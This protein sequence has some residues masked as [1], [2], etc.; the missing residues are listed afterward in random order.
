MVCKSGK[1]F[2]FQPNSSLPRLVL[3]KFYCNNSNVAFPESNFYVTDLYILYALFSDHQAISLMLLCV[4][5]WL[6]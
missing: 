3:D 2:K 6:L 5:I 4:T 1:S